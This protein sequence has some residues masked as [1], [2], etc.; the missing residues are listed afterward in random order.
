MHV[1]A[2]QIPLLYLSDVGVPHVE[3]L[4]ELRLMLCKLHAA[5]VLWT[6]AFPVLSLQLGPVQCTLQLRHFVS[7]DVTQSQEDV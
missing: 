2:K 5:P 7:Y 3:V 1:D 4:Y 6:V